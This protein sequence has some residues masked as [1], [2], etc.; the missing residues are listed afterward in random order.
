MRQELRASNRSMFSRALAAVCDGCW[1]PAAGDPL[2]QP[3]RRRTFVMCRDCGHV[4]ACPRCAVPLTYHSEGEMLVCHH[5]NRRYPA[6]TSVPDCQS[7]RIRFF[8]AGTRKRGG[9]GQAGVPRRAHAALGSGRDRRQGAPRRHPQPKFVAHEADVLIGTQMIAKGLDLP[10]V[11]LVGVIAADVGPVPARFSRRRAHLPTADPGG[12]PRRAQRVGRPGH[13][14]DLSPRPLRG[15]RGQPP[16]LRRLLPPGDRVSPP[17]GLPAL[18][19]AGPTRLLQQPA[20][21]GRGRGD[22]A[23]PGSCATR[24]A[25]WRCPKPT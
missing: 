16:R 2:S 19:P 1:L 12:R 4:E 21:Q 14:P 6:P 5:C 23:W 13:R 11:T 10:L 15:G 3:P 25:A 17:A 7:K 22:R 20:R 9:G 18:A 24:S 8:G